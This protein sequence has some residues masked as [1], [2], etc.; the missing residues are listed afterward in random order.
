[1]SDSFTTVSQLF[2]ALEADRAEDCQADSKATSQ[3][4]ELK[5]LLA[6]KRYSEYPYEE[7]VQASRERV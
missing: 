3:R 5:E 6:S 7:F 2:H 1:M 4:L